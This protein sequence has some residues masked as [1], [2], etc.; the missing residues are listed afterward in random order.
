MCVTALLALTTLLLPGVVRA[1]SFFHYGFTPRA[2]GMGNA[3][4]ATADDWS[5]SYYNPGGVGFQHRPALGFGA[6]ANYVDV[7]PIGVDELK[8]DEAQA[9]YFGAIL[10]LPFDSGPLKDR[11]SIGLAG[12]APVG[13]L[14]QMNVEAPSTPNLLLLRNAHRTNAMYPSIGVQILRGL[15]MGY[16]V[17]AFIDTLGVI[18]AKVDPSG[19]LVTEV[20][21]ELIVTYASTAGLLFRPGEYSDALTGWQFGFVYREE[22][23]TRYS[24]P[25]SAVLD[26][27]PFII[28][29]DAISMFTPR[30]YVTALTYGQEKW[31][32]EADLSF[33]Q[34]SRFPDP[35]LLI[36]V[37]VAIPVVPISFQNSIER[38]PNFHDTF[39][40]RVGVEGTVYTHP[41]VDLRLRG[42]YSYD[43]SPVPPQT[44][45]TNY[46]DTDKHMGATSVGVRW[47]G[48]NDTR[49][50]GPLSFDV[51]YQLQYLPRR[52]H[53]KNEGVETDNPGYP[54]V[55]AEGTLHLVP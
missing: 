44:G 34:W 25:V 46:V 28:R 23:F 18:D 27:I 29:F 14:L 35:N 31:R 15:A 45:F 37:D 48:V 49:F 24:I 54:Q 40:P 4:S 21:Q 17:Q 22:T 30:Q 55:G 2:I 38:T 11:I 16:G 26:Q 43:Q 12:Y 3:F 41:D 1:D 50:D 19:E 51:F 5:A 20:G 33:N 42:G 7:K 47:Y 8:L 13:R 53:N 10:P 39:T 52:V 6:W 32:V 36:Q 9:T